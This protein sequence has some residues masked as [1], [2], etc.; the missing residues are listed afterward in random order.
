MAKEGYKPESKTELIGVRVTT[1][2]DEF[3]AELSLKHRWSKQDL[4]RSMIDHCKT[5]AA[6]GSLEL[7]GN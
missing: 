2:V 3:L 4:I 6:R 1:D 7:K 5:L